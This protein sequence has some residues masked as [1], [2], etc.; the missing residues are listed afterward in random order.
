MP[1]GPLPYKAKVS[2]AVQD[3]QGSGMLLTITITD[4]SSVIRGTT[5]FDFSNRS[6][7]N[8][9]DMEFLMR[10]MQTAVAQQF[11]LDASDFPTALNTLSITMGG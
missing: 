7:Q 11:F 1:L 10:A 2:Q 5:T 3:V 8:A 6:F 9:A 4:N